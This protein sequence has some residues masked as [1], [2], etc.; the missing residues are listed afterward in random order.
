MPRK[1]M[2][3]YTQSWT[4]PNESIKQSIL[5]SQCRGI[6]IISNNATSNELIYFSTSIS[7]KFVPPKNVPLNEVFF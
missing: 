1:H 7:I 2:F 5:I 6:E 3:L 4:H